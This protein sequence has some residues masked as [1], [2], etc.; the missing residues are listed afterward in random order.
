MRTKWFRFQDGLL[1]ASASLALLLP[2]QTLTQ[3]EEK[4][5]AFQTA[6]SS[7]SI[8]GYVDSSPQWDPDATRS[9]S[10]SEISLT[11][12]NVLAT[13]DVVADYSTNNNPTGVWSY[14]WKSTLDGPLSL[15][16]RH[17]FDEY[18]DGAV[19]DYWLKPSGGPSAVYHNPGSVTITNNEGQGN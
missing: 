12:T 2:F 11:D 16:T 3:A 17:G 19:D 1:V 18:P 9:A 14:G 8:S 7:T 10:L 5:S 13:Y 4:L 6:L 15:F